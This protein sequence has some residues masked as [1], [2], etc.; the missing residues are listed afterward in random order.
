MCPIFI[1]FNFDSC[2]VTSLKALTS[3]ESGPSH[4]DQVVFI[5]GVRLLRHMETLKMNII[6]F[7]QSNRK[8]PAF[9]LNTMTVIARKVKCWN[10]SCSALKLLC[11]FIWLC[12]CSVGVPSMLAACSGIQLLSGAE[13]APSACS[14][15]TGNSHPLPSCLCP[16]LTHPAHTWAIWHPEWNKSVVFKCK[17]ET[18][19]FEQR[20]VE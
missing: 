6:L 7:Y 12:M 2:Q 20:R 13:T 4:A 10:P 17:W 19:N 8:M 11:V 1:D 14:L 15:W 9:Q 18:S 5:K 3:S 16:L